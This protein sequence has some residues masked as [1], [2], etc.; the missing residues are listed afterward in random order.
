MIQALGTKHQA[1]KICFATNNKHK[2]EEI[3]KV[4]DGKVQLLSLAEIGCAEELP[5]TGNMIEANSLQK[6]KYIFDKYKVNCFADDSGLEIDALEGKPGVN[7][8]HYSGSRNDLANIN[9]VLNELGNTSDRSANFKT[10]I[11]YAK[12]GE[13]HQ[14]EG[15]IKGKIILEMKGSG[16]FGYDPIFVPD[17]YEHTFAEMPLEQKNKISHRALAVEKLVKFMAPSQPL[18]RKG[19]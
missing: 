14:F 12:D 6:A 10:V 7:S 15:I 1:P 18:P 3:I 17:G 11:T 8:A 19:K 4:L 5:E 16:G 13:F 9:L 2:I